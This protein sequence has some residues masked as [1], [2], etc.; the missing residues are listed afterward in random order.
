[1]IDILPTLITIGMIPFGL[2]NAVVQV[3]VIVGDVPL[4]ALHWNDNPAMPVAVEAVDA[5][6]PF[7]ETIVTD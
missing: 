1:V 6:I 7:T 4:S 2:T 5:A 3:N